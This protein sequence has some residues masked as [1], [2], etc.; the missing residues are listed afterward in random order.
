MIGQHHGAARRLDHGHVHHLSIHLAGTTLRLLE[1]SDHTLCPLEFAAEG[2]KTALIV[3]IC[4]GWM[5]SLP[6]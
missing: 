1:R 4:A 6:T 3:L 2:E 5:A